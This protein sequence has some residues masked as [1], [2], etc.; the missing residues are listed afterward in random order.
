M[1]ECK[2]NEITDIGFKDPDKM[3][4]VTIEEP[5]YKEDT[6][7]ALLRFLKRQNDKK[8]ILLPYNFK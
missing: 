4:E 6:T 5:F 3:H 2:R 8:E 1:L 7:E